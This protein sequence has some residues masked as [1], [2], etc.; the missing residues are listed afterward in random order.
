MNGKQSSK[1]LVIDDEDMEMIRSLKTVT[2]SEIRRG[3]DAD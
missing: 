1:E 2:K 3:P